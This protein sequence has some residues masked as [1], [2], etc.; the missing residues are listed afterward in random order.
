MIDQVLRDPIMWNSEGPFLS[1]MGVSNCV[2]FFRTEK[3]T[4]THMVW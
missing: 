4:D 2:F 3:D 1:R